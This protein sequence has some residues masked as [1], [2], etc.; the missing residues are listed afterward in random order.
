MNRLKRTAIVFA[1]IIGVLVSMQIL[2]GCKPARSTERPILL[3]DTDGE[4]V[5]VEV[6]PNLDCVFVGEQRGGYGAAISCNWERY[7][8]LQEQE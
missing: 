4:I 5:I 7:N 1:F 6:K 3:G 8:K 2:T